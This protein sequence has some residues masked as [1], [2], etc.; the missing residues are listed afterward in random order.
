MPR[1]TSATYVYAVLAGKKKLGKSPPG[2]EG[3]EKPRLIDAGGGYALVA[4]TVPLP[5]YGAK[6]I[7]KKL[8]DLDWVQQIG[9]AHED[10]VE[11]AAT[12]GTVVPM[13]LFTLFEN[14]ESAVSNLALRKKVLERVVSR[15]EECDEWGLRILFDEAR[16]KS[17]APKPTKAKTGTSFLL[18]K[19]N[20]VDAARKVLTAAKTDVAD[21]YERLEKVSKRS[22]RR[23]APNRELAGQLL[24]DAV[25]LV[26]RKGKTKFTKEVS[27]T[28]QDLADQG[29]HVTLTGPWPAYSFVEDP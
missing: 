7:E 2:L 25:F 17:L 1:A 6:A 27:G 12:L 18:K 16:A 23:S 5:Q 15:I 28:A 9:Q 21:L 3:A 20:D 4:S 22:L 24:L 10:V 29:F 19:K 14:D 11:H 13:K 26:A 8:V